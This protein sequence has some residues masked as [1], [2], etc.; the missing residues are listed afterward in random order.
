MNDNLAY[1]NDG[2]IAGAATNLF[3][4]LCKAI[5]FGVRPEDAIRSATYTPA[6]VVGALDEV[7]TIENGKRADFLVLNDDFSL[8]TVYLRGMPLCSSDTKKEL[9]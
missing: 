4:G 7:G 6:R 2:T 8:R 5:Q 3:S 1:L 9:L